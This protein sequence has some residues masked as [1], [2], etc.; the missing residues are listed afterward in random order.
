[1]SGKPTADAHRRRSLRVIHQALP[2]AMLR[3]EEFGTPQRHSTC[4]Q[5]A[6]SCDDKAEQVAIKKGA[7]TDRPKIQA[8]LVEENTQSQ[9][10]ASNLSSVQRKP[11]PL[12]NPHKFPHL[13]ELYMELQ[14][15]QALPPPIYP[16]ERC[17]LLPFPVKPRTLVLDLDETLIRRQAPGVACETI[18]TVEVPQGSYLIGLNLR[19]Y[20]T[21]V[22]TELEKHWELVV[23]TAAQKSYADAIIDYIDPGKKLISHRFYREHCV[24]VNSKPIKDLSIL[25][26]RNLANTVIV[27]NSIHSFAYHLSNGVPIPAWRGSL[28]DRELLKLNRYLKKLAACEDVR[29]E[30]RRTFDLEHFCREFRKA[31]RRVAS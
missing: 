20:L 16:I 11:M 4:L 14:A 26:H 7:M 12:H 5:A 1:M 15:I 28:K 8:L 13:Y 6:D 27:D 25:S 9:Q 22:L 3:T 18:L 24:Y 17:L 23:F 2:I 10:P 31:E 19:P 30:N 29:E 21:Q